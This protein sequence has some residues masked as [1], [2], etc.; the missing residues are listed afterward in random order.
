MLFILSGNSFPS[1]FEVLAKKIH[2][3]LF[4][5]LAHIYGF[6]YREVVCLALHPHLNSLF[7]H[8]MTF[9]L[10]YN[11]LEEKETEILDDLYKKLTDSGNLNSGAAGE[12]GDSGTSK[13][14]ADGASESTNQTATSSANATTTGDKVANGSATTS[15]KVPATSETTA[16]PTSQSSASGPSGEHLDGTTPSSDCLTNPSQDK[17]GEGSSQRSRSPSPGLPPPPPPLTAEEAQE[18]QFYDTDNNHLTGDLLDSQPLI[19][20]ESHTTSVSL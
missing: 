13:D 17:A 7:V 3:Y 15:T 19:N 20:V 4:Q 18:G 14:E 6:H 8:F 10:M 16:N 11:V 2:R 1:S 9:N 12:T 5:V